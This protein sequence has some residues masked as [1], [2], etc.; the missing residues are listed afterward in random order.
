MRSL[1]LLVRSVLVPTAVIVLLA[2]WLRLRR[3]RRRLEDACERERNLRLSERAGR[4]AAERKLRHGLQQ[5]QQQQQAPA[6]K[7]DNETTQDCT[8]VPIGRIAS[9]FI[10]RRGTPRQG[11]LAPAARATLK[12]DAHVVQPRAALEGLEDFSHVWLL[13]DFHENTNA[14]KLKPLPVAGGSRGGGSSSGS[15]RTSQVKAKVHPPGLGGGRVGLFATRTPHRPNPIGL[16]AARLLEIRGDTL[17]LGGADLVDGTPILDVKPY[18]RH[19][20]HEDARVPSWCEHPTDASNITEVRFAPAAAAALEQLTP[21][22]RFFSEVQQ[23]R[24]AIEQMLRLDIRSVVRRSAA[25][26]TP[27][28]R[29]VLSQPYAHEHDAR[30]SL[31]PPL[32]HQGRGQAVG[33]SAGQKYTC[34]FDNL[35]LSFSTFDTHVEVVEIAQQLD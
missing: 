9:C 5:Q 32:Q 24:N 13:Y 2:D 1:Y 28:L 8:Y 18:L 19:D 6:C 16:S 10:E 14:T 31:S 34:R 7:S 4:T 15:S 35:I 17:I 21:R 23:A 29:P 20:L 3:Q 27:P 12:L 30:I 26:H 25:R 22:L 33:N 11:L